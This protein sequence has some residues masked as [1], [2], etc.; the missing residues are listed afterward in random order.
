METDPTPEANSITRTP[1]AAPQD[2]DGNET[3]IKFVS[4]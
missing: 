4:L 2:T 1:Q 3:K